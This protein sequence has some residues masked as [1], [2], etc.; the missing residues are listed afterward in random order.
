MINRQ[1][2]LERIGKARVMVVGCGALGNEV[3]KTLAL[4]G[5]R[6]FVL[7]DMDVVEAGNLTRSVM[8]GTEDVGRRKVDAAADW[9]AAFR[10]GI[11]VSTIHGD[12]AH[13]VGINLVRSVDVVV[14]CVDSRW[15]RY[16]INRLAFRAGKPWIDGGIMGMVGTCRV[17]VWNENCYAC[18]LGTDEM[19]ELRRRMPCSGV[20]RRSIEAGHAPTSAVAASII[21]AVQAQETLKMICG[22][23]DMCGRMFTY[24]GESLRAAFVDFRAW[25]DDCPVHEKW[26]PVTDRKIYNYLT[27]SE[28]LEILNEGFELRDDCFVDYIVS[29]KDDAKYEVMCPGRAV[30]R[31]FEAGGRL[32]GELL[33]GF[34]QHEYRT[35]DASFPYPGL[36]LARLGIPENDVIRTKTRR[37]ILVN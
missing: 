13:D 33:S 37:F 36:T 2:D 20:I 7:V 21:G 26:E 4:S 25:D 10:P 24:D 35:I 1:M 16:C 17:F 19:N 5:V 31:A 18:S 11:K 15:A 29:R 27:V 32:A 9:L 14:G 6:N 8:Y 3:V 22:E 12:V 30:E 23:P 34:Y 28:T